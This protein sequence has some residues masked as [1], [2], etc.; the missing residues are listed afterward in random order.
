MKSKRFLFISFI[1]F[2]VSVLVLI[3]SILSNE[4]GEWYAKNVSSIIRIALSHLTGFFTFSL[5]EIAVFLLLPALAAFV[6]FLIILLLKKSRVIFTAL[7][8]LVSFALVLACLF[9]NTFAVCYFRYPVEESMG[10]QSL[11]VSRKEIYEAASIIKARLESMLDTVSFDKSGA[12]ENPNNWSETSEK[13]DDGYDLLCEKFPFI[14]RINVLPKKL[15]VSPIMTY[16]HISGIYMPFTGEANVNTNYP[17]YVVAYTVAHEKAH[18]RG[19]AGEDEA[20]FIAFLACAMSGDKYLEYS[21]YMSMYDYFLDAVYKYDREMYRYLIHESDARVLGEMYAYS[22]FFDKYRDSAASKV[23]DN[24]NDTYI[25]A[26]GDSNGVES[27]GRVV[28]LVCGYI[29]KNSLP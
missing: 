21:A 16:T 4:F 2:V 1:F 20:N 17:D 11:A 8:V 9:I 13:I 10:F 25:K 3:I 7:R 5:A 23:A 15:I 24:V 6:A 26:M 22:V 27:Y 19:I 29:N 12:S 28:E 18:Q 14:T